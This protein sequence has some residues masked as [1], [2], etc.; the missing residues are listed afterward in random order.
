HHDAPRPVPDHAADVD[1]VRGGHHIGDLLP[2]H[3]R[4][5]LGVPAV[6]EALNLRVLFTNSVR[7]GRDQDDHSSAAHR[8]LR[9][10]NPLSSLPQVVVGGIGFGN[11]DVSETWLRDSVDGPGVFGAFTVRGY[12]IARDDV[13]HTLLP[14]HHHVDDEAQPGLSRNLLHFQA[15]GV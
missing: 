10:I 4:L 5:D 7:A 11:H 12:R 2:L 14:V 8:Q 6:A 1:E 13:D 3:A 9:G 15:H